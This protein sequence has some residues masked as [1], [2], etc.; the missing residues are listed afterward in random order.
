MSDRDIRKHPHGAEQVPDEQPPPDP[1]DLSNQTSL[2]HGASSR[3][4]VPAAVLA[5]VVIVLSVIAMQLQFV[6]PVIAI[7]FVVAL[8]F[9]MLVVSRRTP[10]IR[11]RNRTLAW[12]MG[13][14][15]IGTAVLFMTL[16]AVEASGLVD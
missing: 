10:D 13:A 8:W 6:I 2:Q 4:L 7:V 15:A 11:H 3:W 12:L 9:V 1:T 5:G 16:Y 14:M